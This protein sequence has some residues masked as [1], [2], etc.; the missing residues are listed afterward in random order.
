MGLNLN[1]RMRL[2]GSHRTFIAR[3]AGIAVA[4]NFVMGGLMAW[5]A[6]RSSE[7]VSLWGTRGFAFDIVATTVFLTFFTSFFVSKVAYRAIRQNRVPSV[8]WPTAVGLFERIRPRPFLGSLGVA[9]LAAVCICPF[10]IGAFAL[11][12]AEVVDLSTYVGFKALYSAV[13]AAVVTPAVVLMAWAETHW[14]ETH[15]NDTGLS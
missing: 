7:S 3:Q 14:L 4:M 9:G 8:E 15:A 6:F 1:R 11:L 2:V 10:V 13:L 12:D 5:V